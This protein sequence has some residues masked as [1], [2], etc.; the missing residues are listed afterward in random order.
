MS[1]D[2]PSATDHNNE[3]PSRSRSC[4]KC[5]QEGHFSRECPNANER[6]DR[7]PPRR[8]NNHMPRNRQNGND[9]FYNQR[10]GGQLVGSGFIYNPFTSD[11]F[12][13]PSGREDF[14][15]KSEMDTD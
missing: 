1:R 10:N 9:N 12:F 13:F 8:E 15:N 11:N 2:C 5:N 14:I 3:R 6:N 7:R 4:F